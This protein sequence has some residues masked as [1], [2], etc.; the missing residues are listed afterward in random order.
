[1]LFD[2]PDIVQYCPSEERAVMIHEGPI[3]KRVM[4]KK[5]CLYYYYNLPIPKCES[6][7]SNT[8]IDPYEN[9]HSWFNGNINFL[10]SR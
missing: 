9:R 2:R 7:D 8:F 6:I 3:K 4:P 5:P 1:M 10:V